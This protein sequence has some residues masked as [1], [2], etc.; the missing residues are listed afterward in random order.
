MK[1][2]K[3]PEEILRFVQPLTK[4]M[5][6]RGLSLYQ[7]AENMDCHSAQLYNAYKNPSIKW[8]AAVADALEV[9]VAIN[10]KKSDEN[11]KIEKKERIQASLDTLRADLDKIE[12]SVKSL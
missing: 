2:R 10:F 7:V 1:N 6:S 8:I 5:E 12:E 3:S 9:T 4:L 11:L